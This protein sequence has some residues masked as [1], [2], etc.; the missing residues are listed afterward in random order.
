MLDIVLALDGRLD[1]VKRL[2]IDET[3]QRVAFCKSSNSADAMLINATSEIACYAN[4]KDA[5]GT[6]GQEVNV[7]TPHA[8]IMQNVDG[9]DKPGHDVQNGAHP[10]PTTHAR[11]K[12]PAVSCRGFL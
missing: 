5:V 12:P 1:V 10:A 4:I 7:S 11:K 8:P 6:V 3:L 2:E 9:R